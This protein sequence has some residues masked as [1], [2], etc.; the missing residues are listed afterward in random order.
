MLPE[1]AIKEFKLA[2]KKKFG[3]DLSDEEARRRAQN[4]VNLYKAVYGGSPSDTQIASKA[5]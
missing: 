1:E 2:Y 5:V 4:L 3:I